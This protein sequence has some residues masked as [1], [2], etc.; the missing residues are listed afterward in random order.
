MEALI[1]GALWL[2]ACI[3]VGLVGR[4]RSIG[5]LGVFLLSLVLSPILMILVLQMTRTPE[6]E[7]RDRRSS[8]Q[9]S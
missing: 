2:L 1:L 3:L 9:A 6:R 7:R 8:S 5:F 4:R